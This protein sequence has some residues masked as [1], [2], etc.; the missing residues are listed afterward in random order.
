[1]RN[2]RMLT[3]DELRNIIDGMSDDERKSPVLT[4]CDI[5]YNGISRDQLKVVPDDVDLTNFV[6]G[7]RKRDIRPGRRF[8]AL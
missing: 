3:W 6:E 7:V 2:P 5:G 8:I 4:C 1:M